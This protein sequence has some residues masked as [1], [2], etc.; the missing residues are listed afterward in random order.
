MKNL[1]FLLFLAIAI[2]AQSQVAINTDG[3]NPDNSAMLD[4]KSTTKGMLIP[5][6]T[7]EQRDAIVS[8]ATGLLIF[9]TQNNLYYLN[10]GTPAAPNWVVMSSRWISNG[11][12]IY[13]SE[14][15]VGIG[16]TTPSTK[17]DIAGGNWDLTNG[18]GDFR[19]GNDLYRLKA[20]IAL[21]GG[22]AGD[23]GIMQ[24][25]QP[26]GYNLLSLGAQGHKLIF[27]NGSSQKVGIGTDNPVATL[28]VQGTL[29]VADGTQGTGKVL[30][31]DA[32]GLASW[33]TNPS[34]N[35][36][37]LTGN[38]GTSSGTNFIGTTDNVPLMFKVNNQQAGKIEQT[39]SNTS[40]GFNSM[41]TN[42][43]GTSNSAFGF[44]AMYSNTTG[45]YNTA[46]GLNTL[47]SNTIGTGNSAYGG[48]ALFYNTSGGY[49]TATG[50]QALFLNTT[51]AN[52]TATGVGS[53]YENASGSNNTA[54]GHSALTSN[55]TGSDNTA[56]GY[57]ALNYNTTGDFNTATGHSALYSNTTG[58]FNTAD[59]QSALNKNTIGYENTA[60]GGNALYNNTDGY[61]NTAVGVSALFSNTTGIYNTSTGWQSLYTNT[62][63]GYNTANGYWALSFNTT[64]YRNTST[65]FRSLTYNSTGFYNTADG[66]DAL[67]N[68][69]EGFQNTAIG[70]HTL[71]LNHIGS[72]NTALGY[73]AGTN[74]DGWFNVTCL[75]TDATATATDM[76][77][78]GNVFVNSIGGQVGW[79]TL[80]DGRFKENVVEDVPGLS[81]INQLRPVTYQ[82]N[83]ERINEFT[84]VTENHKKLNE[85]EPSLKFITGENL[86]QVT[87]G[88]IAQEVEAAAR[89]VG[90]NFSGVDAPKNEHDM[91]GLRY[92]EFVVPLVKAVQELSKT[93]DMQQAL[94]EKQQQKIEELEEAIKTLNQ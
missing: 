76:V 29:R 39:T 22:G 62:T 72:Y 94:I 35:S 49:N 85:Q 41:K 61:Q 25:G 37:S 13:F 90:Y 55:T 16:T 47:Y 63:G 4:V 91:Y 1:L 40:F 80:S 6:M 31:S 57:T 43:S 68:N 58:Y 9:C 54:T 5:R 36:W 78:I 69:T 66:V 52:N 23:A 93:N 50:L 74:F 81:F 92:A 42:S 38:S 48:L 24:Y 88:F 15:Y 67:L 11:S 26:G 89:S 21:D 18:E 27:L 77:R 17:L 46:S 64:G 32:N 28:D 70:A 73:N 12:D 8:P 65:G 33:V 60:I 14:G 71:V 84:G 83:R 44:D 3:S 19:I 59:G 20:G 45:N 2:N 51:G 75:G 79:T 86:S 56:T 30:T 53:L 82:L 10:K 34:S 7:A 87:T